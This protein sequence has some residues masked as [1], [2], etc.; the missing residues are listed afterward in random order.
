MDKYTAVF[1]PGESQGL[2][3][4]VGCRLSGCRVRHD[5][6]DLEAVAAAYGNKMDNVEEMYRFLQNFNLPRLN[7]EEIEI[8]NY[9]ITNTEIEA[10]I[11]NLPQK[12]SPGPDSFTGEFD[13]TFTE[14]LMPVLLKLF[15]KIAKKEHFQS[16][17]MRPPSPW[18]Q[19]QTKTT[20]QTKTTGQYHWWIQ[21]QKSSTKV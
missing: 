5:W 3:S 4:L 16:H 8:M 6:S 2:R 12:K 17:S 19:N 9:P 10:V 7:Q 18:C 1:L 20:Q 13:Q 11:K 14:E 15:R 21:M